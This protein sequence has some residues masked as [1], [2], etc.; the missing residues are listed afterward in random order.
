MDI[1]TRFCIYKWGNRQSISRCWKAWTR[2]IKIQP[3]SAA[4]FRVH[5]CSMTQGNI[6]SPKPCSL[7][8]VC[9]RCGFLWCFKMVGPVAGMF[10]FFMDKNKTAFRP[11]WNESQWT[12]LTWESQKNGSEGYILTRVCRLR[13]C[14]ARAAGRGEEHQPP[15]KCRAGR[16]AGPGLV[17]SAWAAGSNSL[18]YFQS[19]YL[20]KKAIYAGALIRNLWLHLFWVRKIQHKPCVKLQYWLAVRIGTY[21]H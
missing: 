8:K 21:L 20:T 3:D 10:Y 5:Y 1:K 4:V 11:F 16:S 13:H 9:H 18:L 12:G 17:L 6:S 14:N 7:F 2:N 19:L 15:C